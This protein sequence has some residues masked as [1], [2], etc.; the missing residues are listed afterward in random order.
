[1]A[2]ADAVSATIHV[3]FAG[4]WTGTV[5]FVTLAV[6]P[7]AADGTLNARPLAA[8][9]GKLQ[10]ISRVSAVLLLLTG[11]HMAGTLYTVDTLTG[12]PRGHAVLAMVALWLALAALVEIGAG[13]LTHGTEADKVRTPAAEAKPYMQA[14]AVVAV[15]LLLDA[16]ALAGGLV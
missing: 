12:S 14:A 10:T 11:G 13:K 8:L 7:L 15:L 5:L 3:A 2:L 16:G 4:L 6:L 1:M 9:T